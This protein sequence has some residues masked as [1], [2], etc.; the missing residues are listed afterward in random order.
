MS[1]SIGG[2]PAGGGVS[3]TCVPDSTFKTELDALWTAGT[4]IIGKLVGLTF[5]ANYEVTSPAD[6]AQANGII[7]EFERTV[8]SGSATYN[9]T[10]QL[11][12][13]VDQNGTMHAATQIV[14]VPYVATFNLQDTILVNST[15]YVGVKNGGTGGFGACIAKDVPASGYADILI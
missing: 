15:T 3:C 11:W 10:C 14:N 5:A 2:G 4:A 6:G 8:T 13:Y 7:T 12:S 9:L 1:R